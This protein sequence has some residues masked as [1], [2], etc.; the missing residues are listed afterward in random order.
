[1]KKTNAMRLLDQRKISYRTE[2][3][4]VDP[5]DLSAMT[6]ASKIGIEPERL[7]KTLLVRGASGC[8]FAVIPTDAE[9]DLKALAKAV[10]EKKMAVVPL[11]EVQTLTGYLRGGVTV[12]GAKKAFPTFLD[13][14]ALTFD[15]VSVSAG[16]RGQQILLSP[17]DY[18][19][20]TGATV[21][22]IAAA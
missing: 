8:C 1:M 17:E 11:K 2:R 7:L 20:A 15:E 21:S 9:L 5:S 3:Y 10:G 22:E 19:A 6:V 4:Q 14:R 13:Q 18:V 16:V 12:L